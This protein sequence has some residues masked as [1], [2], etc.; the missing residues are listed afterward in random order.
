[1]CPLRSCPIGGLVAMCFV[2]A[3][4]APAL[5]RDVALSAFELVPPRVTV[6]IANPCVSSPGGGTGAC[7]LP[8]GTCTQGVTSDFCT[9]NLGGIYQG[10]ATTCAGVTCTGCGNF[11][12]QI[13]RDLNGNDTI[14]LGTDE[15]LKELLPAIPG[16]P[17]D[18][19]APTAVGATIVDLTGFSSALSTLP[20][21]NRLRN[22]DR[23]LARAVITDDDNT[24][25]EAGNAAIV[26]VTVTFDA[27]APLTLSPDGAAPVIRYAIAAPAA[28]PPINVGWTVRGA[29]G[30]TQ[31]LSD[32]SQLTPGPHVVTLADAGP[33]ESLRTFL[34]NLG[35]GGRIANG[36][37]IAAGLATNLPPAFT[38]VG[39]NVAAAVSVDITA[40]IPG[41]TPRLQYRVFSPGRVNSFTLD[42]FRNGGLV[43]TPPERIPLAPGATNFDPGAARDVL[44]NAAAFQA[45]LSGLPDGSRVSNGDTLRVQI[46]GGLG[47]APEPSPETPVTVTVNATAFAFDSV[48]DDG[49]S[50]NVRISYEIDAPAIINSFGV[51][52]RR[53]GVLLGTLSGLNDGAGDFEPGP[54]ANRPLSSPEFAAALNALANGDRVRN[55]ELLTGRLTVPPGTLGTQEASGAAAVTINV[56]NFDF[57]NTDGSGAVFSYNVSAPARI[58]SFALNLVRDANG[59][60]AADGADATLGAL[61]FNGGNAA[62]E[63]LLTL[64]AHLNVS[65]EN[66]RGVLD[67][68]TPG[69][70]VADGQRLFAVPSTADA[71]VQSVGGKVAAVQIRLL[72]LTVDP[73]G[74]SVAMPYEILAPGRI[75]NFVARVGSDTDPLNP[76]L[77][78]LP[79][80]ADDSQVLAA[81]TLAAAA[82]LPGS[83][84]VNLAFA[85]SL[86]DPI[87]TE[88]YVATLDLDKNQVSAVPESAVGIN[89]DVDDNIQLFTITPR[90][91]LISLTLGTAPNGDRLALV[92]YRVTQSL[93][94]SFGLEFRLIRDGGVRA[95]Y[96]RLVTDPAVRDAGEFQFSDNLTSSLSAA[97]VDLR[98]GDTLCVRLFKTDPANPD[99]FVAPTELC[100]L[101]RVD[102]RAVSFAV[103]SLVE[104]GAGAVDPSEAKRNERA[105]GRVT[106]AVDGPASVAPFN[107]E[108]VLLD[109]GAEKRVALQRVNSPLV[110]APGT[111]SLEI[112]FGAA[113]AALGAP[114]TG[115]LTLIARIDATAEIPESDEAN[116]EARVDDFIYPVDLRAI[117]LTF[118][119]ATNFDQEQADAGRESAFGVKVAFEVTQNTLNSPFQV[120]TFAVTRGQGE[121]NDTFVELTMVSTQVNGAPLGG[122]LPVGAHTLTA[123][124]LGPSVAQVASDT[125]IVLVRFDAAPDAD[126]KFSNGAI[127]EIDERNNEVSRQS[128][129][130]NLAVDS[131]GDGLTDAEE[132]RGFFVSRYT[133]SQF[134]EPLT[135]EER[136]KSFACELDGRLGNGLFRWRCLVRTDPLNPDTD[137][138]GISDLDE[139]VTFAIA[140]DA[141]GRVEGAG[142]SGTEPLV[143]GE[144]FAR[145]RALRIFS[146]KPFA[147]IRTD[148]TRADTDG[149]GLPDSIDPAPQIRP[150]LFNVALAGADGDVELQARLLNFDQ[151]GDG[152]LEAPDANGDGVPDFTRFNE[153]TIEGL[154]GIDFSNDGTLRDGFDLGGVV[155]DSIEKD[156]LADF[157]VT[158][159]QVAT[160][161]DPAKRTFA[162]LSGVDRR[163]LAPRFGSFRVGSFQSGSGNAAR[164]AQVARV[165]VVF[166]QTPEATAQGIASVPLMRR[167]T[168]DAAERIINRRGNGRIDQVDEAQ[169]FESVITLGTFPVDNCPGDLT[170]AASNTSVRF[171]PEQSD[172]D[173]DGIGDTCD[174]DADN[175]GVSDGFERLVTCGAPCGA[176]VIAA[177]PLVLAG[178]L[179]GK[180]WHRRRPRR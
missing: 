117:S 134:E 103:T 81:E 76:G 86:M 157:G 12:I 97:A 173:N 80:T 163:T 47:Y 15:L 55:G 70:R 62:D 167:P 118:T 5:A 99:Q 16:D 107:I 175:D 114:A 89:A 59:N 63:S 6:T 49:A 112:K 149:D 168:G 141:S 180:W 132:V 34:D 123:V 68:L 25:N 72:P 30:P 32:L 148:P 126:G 85:K 18:F 20:P 128:V 101:V 46:P 78:D 105:V 66:L 119:S 140:A 52:L 45:P 177:M 14:D 127:R 93:A 143:G 160:S 136:L 110:L 100:A 124:V 44:L 166:G 2:V 87:R 19:V 159:D 51:E 37:T 104:A 131:D 133:V 71:A 151:D 43:T 92:N 11:S 90:V 22:G 73:T 79:G 91:S 94:K 75:E 109:G 174:P 154:F 24:N 88:N 161:D 23:L 176:G 139:I 155:A 67:A 137:G 42:L 164:Y 125:F 111:H 172:I 28:V 17:R 39:S 108:I 116:N 146:G 145:F 4:A 64:G 13:F 60:A 170:D 106:Y 120:R 115:P 95:V 48:S 58:N 130:T 169:S 135:P 138:D 36:D 152:F 142:Q 74:V 98:D 9:T 57:S 129:G 171:N 162:G 65:I 53:G 144:G 38:P 61:S 33:P 7:C 50:R 1:M 69:N 165:A 31:V 41:A 83:N 54:H 147:G 3:A 27:V 121:T 40:L 56:T 179:S 178:L 35:D 113:L 156:Y 153:L 158:A 82:V 21:N 122:A 84:V 10:P 29:P 150:S 102:L 8:D 96:T 77:D 26:V